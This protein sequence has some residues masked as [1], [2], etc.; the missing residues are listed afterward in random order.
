M[1]SSFFRLQGPN[2]TVRFGSGAEYLEETMR[3]IPSLL[4]TITLTLLA[5]LAAA[6]AQAQTEDSSIHEVLIRTWD[7]QFDAPEV[8]PS[9]PTHIRLVNEG[10]D[11]H[12]VWLVRLLD[13]KTVTDL[14][15]FLSAGEAALPAW[16]VDVGGPNTPGHPGE[17]TSAYLDLKPGD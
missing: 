17:E 3:R 8:V 9:G 1:R 13:G 10:P 7:Y 5:L 16:A 6:P 11:F 4:S 14:T 2:G 15:D 12:H